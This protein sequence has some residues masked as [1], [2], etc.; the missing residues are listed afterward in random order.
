MLLA[1]VGPIKDVL[2]MPGRIR[3]NPKFGE[4]DSVSEESQNLKSFN[5]PDQ[6]VN[7]SACVLL[8][9]V[10]SR[11]W[12]VSMMDAYMIQLR[13][14][15]NQRDLKCPS[16]GSFFMF[17]GIAAPRTSFTHAQIIGS[18]IVELQH[19][20]CI[21]SGA[22]KSLFICLKCG[23]RSAQ[24]AK[25]LYWQCRCPCQRRCQRRQRRRHEHEHEQE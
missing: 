14:W 3:N 11:P 6:T 9:A 7:H 17:A 16:C 21:V 12:F 4:Q 22:P 2:T 18:N 19:N 20:E 8:L 5:K 24:S 23:S 15:H 10:S 25:R 1:P 13:E